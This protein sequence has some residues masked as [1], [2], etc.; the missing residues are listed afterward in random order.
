MYFPIKS[1]KSQQ[2]EA[3]LKNKWKKNLILAKLINKER[4]FAW[5]EF[6]RN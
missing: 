3:V 5:V 6:E 4:I 2:I 1:A